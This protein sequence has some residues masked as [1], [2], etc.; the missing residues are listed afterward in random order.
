MRMLL[1]SEN[2]QDRT[3]TN[4]LTNCWEGGGGMLINVMRKGKRSVIVNLPLYQLWNTYATSPREYWMVIENQKSSPT[5]IT[6]AR[7]SKLSLFLSLPVCRWLIL[8]AG[9]SEW[10][11][12]QIIRRRKS[13]VRFKSFNTRCILLWSYLRQTKAKRF[14]KMPESVEEEYVTLLGGRLGDERYDSINIRKQ[15]TSSIA[16]LHCW[17]KGNTR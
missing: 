13:L 12:S 11:R 5:P 17:R 8:L 4:K 3:V 2:Y 6:H 10:E 16:F 1:V 14:S 7:K 15:V 9:G